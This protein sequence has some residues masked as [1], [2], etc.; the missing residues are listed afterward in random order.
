MILAKTGGVWLTLD[1][2]NGIQCLS[3]LSPTTTA[4]FNFTAIT[5][6]VNQWLFI[7]CA[8]DVVSIN[9]TTGSASGFL[10]LHIAGQNMR[11]LK[12][13]SFVSTP[14]TLISAAM[15]STALTLYPTCT[16]QGNP[17]SEYDCPM[18]TQFQIWGLNSLDTGGGMT[19]LD[20]IL[21]NIYL[22]VMNHRG[23][24]NAL[25]GALC[26]DSLYGE[27]I[28]NPMTD[29]D[30]SCV[31]DLGRPCQNGLCEHFL[32]TT[33]PLN[34]TATTFPFEDD[35]GCVCLTGFDGAACDQIAT[36]TTTT[37]TAPVT[38]TQPPSTT[39][40]GA[41]TTTAGSSSGLSDTNKIIVIVVT[42]VVGG[43]VIFGV[44]AWVLVSKYSGEA[45]VY[46]GAT[47][48]A[49]AGNEQTSIF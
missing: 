2:V 11:S 29:F 10:Y 16:T 17:L 47:R 15:T 22:T 34:G 36:T 49:R 35:W 30:G 20:N 39:L 5:M 23:T 7:S 32:G 42:T 27:T 21:F 45:I 33:S 44:L 8:L 43:L 38:T 26:V 18:I 3:G 41:T 4:A 40:L 25:Q 28:G 9:S 48:S 6:Q 37:T 24:L 31:L 14:V 19:V 12:T 46:S 13:T 1:P